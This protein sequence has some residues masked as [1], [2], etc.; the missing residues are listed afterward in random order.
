MFTAG[1]AWMGQCREDVQLNCACF[2]DEGLS[3]TEQ[4]VS[5]GSELGHPKAGT[6]VL[7]QQR[8]VLSQLT[9]PKVMGSHT[10]P[11]NFPEPTLTGTADGGWQ[12]GGFTQQ[13]KPQQGAEVC[14]SL[15]SS[16]W[17]E[18]TCSSLPLLS[19]C[20]S[21]LPRTDGTCSSNAELGGGSGGNMD[22]GG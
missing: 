9:H 2:C 3:V 7:L 4:M 8:G 5:C 19:I 6:L 22:L 17:V 20:R 10:T 15:I 11:A 1:F 16:L 18:P 12:Q 21:L 13:H 14:S